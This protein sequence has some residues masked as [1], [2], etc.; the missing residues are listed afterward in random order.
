MAVSIER[1]KR[2]DRRLS[3]YGPPQGCCERRRR[4]ERRLP[5]LVEATMSDSDWER[6]FG[7]IPV[8]TTVSVD[9]QDQAADI[10]GRARD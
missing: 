5:E 7:R 2:S 6:L 9:A 3:D 4:T 1:R 10:F 8:A